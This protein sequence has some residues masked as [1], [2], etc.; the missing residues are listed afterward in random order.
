MKGASDL[1]GV[2][3][4]LLSLDRFM[5]QREIERVDLIKIDTET[6]EPSVLRGMTEALRRDRPTMVCEILKGR[7]DAA[8]IE[9]LLRPLGYQFFL[10]T[11]GGPQ[12]KP[13]IVGH[14]EFLNYL[15]TARAS[16][17]LA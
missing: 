6:T 17:D 15:F 11:D 4:P 2:D 13:T 3:V 16:R 7:V 12:L 1:T 14:P 10:L 9:A 8:S 5:A